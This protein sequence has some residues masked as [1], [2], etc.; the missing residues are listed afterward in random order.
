MRPIIFS[1]ISIILLFAFG[2]E[3][4][5]SP[6][7]SLTKLNLAYKEVDSLFS[8][9]KSE[10]KIRQRRVDE[11]KINLKFTNISQR[12]GYWGFAFVNGSIELDSTIW[13][14][15]T[16]PE[17]EYLLFHEL[18][19]SILKRNHTNVK[20]K[21]GEYKSLMLDMSAEKFSGVYF[22]VV[23]RKYYLDELFGKT[24][25]EPYWILNVPLVQNSN[26]KVIFNENFNE[27][28][29]NWDVNAGKIVNGIFWLNK[30]SKLDFPFKINGAN[31][32]EL[33]Y[34]VV[35][36]NTAN[37]F[38]LSLGELHDSFIFN[39]TAQ[40]E[41]I[42][43]PYLPK[44]WIG[45]E[46][47]TMKKIGNLSYTIRKKGA[48]MYYYLN[49]DLVYYFDITNNKKDLPVSIIT[50]LETSIGLDKIT[51]FYY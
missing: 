15:M 30:G 50:S 19:H 31:D 20:F 21:N 2:C 18:G 17:K 7:K 33:V 42:K 45:I 37:N 27:N 35:S 16:T 10:A 3:N 11:D 14:S 46:P 32:F 29:P 9:F 48:K 51:L 41:L 24:E 22:Y 38:L 4:E 6:N 49:N 12:L 40:K 36:N 13:Y 1:L 28:K 44:M 43:I 23:R 5:V 26:N 47:T 34:E 25:T 8:V 39:S